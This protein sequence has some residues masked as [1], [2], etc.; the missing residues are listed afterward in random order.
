MPQNDRRTDQDVN[1]QAT[2]VR[3]YRE[4]E[5]R[6]DAI[7]LATD[8][9]FVRGV[10]PARAKAFAKL[11]VRTV[12]DLIE[13]FPFR[14]ELEPKSQP[15]DTLEFGVIATIVGELGRARSS[16][17]FAKTTVTTSVVDGTGRCRVRWFNS[18]YL[19]DRLEPDRVVL[20]R[21]RHDRV[22][23]RL[24][25]GRALVVEET[26]AELRDRLQAALLHH[27][28]DVAVPTF[29]VR[30]PLPLH[31]ELRPGQLVEDWID[32]AQ[33]EAVAVQEQHLVRVRLLQCAEL[34]EKVCKPFG[35]ADHPVEG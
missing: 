26:A 29:D 19:L 2:S 8:I 15:I 5:S 14:H 21:E 28:L 16:G 18:P 24:R 27:A 33:C 12:L 10:G 1:A 31:G 30:P 17:R 4:P 23:Q 34:D 11:G 25:L 32:I 9:Q 22:D 35:R 3:P 6:S 20:L 13:Y 7:G